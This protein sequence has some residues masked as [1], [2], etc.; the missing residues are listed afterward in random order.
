[1]TGQIRNTV[2]VQLTGLALRKTSGYI[3]YISIYKA[4][5]VQVRLYSLTTV[6]LELNFS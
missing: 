3:S 1:M 4:L 2:T 5:Q 6:F